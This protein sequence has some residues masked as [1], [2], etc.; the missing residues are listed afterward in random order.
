MSYPS[1]MMTPKEM[2]GT[3]YRGLSPHKITPMLGVHE[4]EI[5]MARLPMDSLGGDPG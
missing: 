5:A 1:G 4:P 3:K 2:T